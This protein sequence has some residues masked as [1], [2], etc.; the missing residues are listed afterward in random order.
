MFARFKTDKKTYKIDID[1]LLEVDITETQTDDKVEYGVVVATT[2]GVFADDFKS[3]DDAYESV[4]DFSE[5]DVHINVYLLGE[6][7]DD[8]ATEEDALA[9]IEET[10]SESEYDDADAYTADV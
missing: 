8:T 1:T 2:K 5:Q 3:L 10:Y 4:L 9:H 7:V 6:A